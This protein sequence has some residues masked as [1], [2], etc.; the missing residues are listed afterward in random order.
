MG[1]DQELFPNTE[2]NQFNIEVWLPNGGN[3]NQTEDVV[4]RLENEIEKDE[5]VLG[6]ASFVGTSS[7]RFH[8]TYAPEFPRKNFAQIFITTTGKEATQELA[9]EYIKKFEG[10]VPDGYIR[11]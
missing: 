5:R 2:R 11:I 3:L 4:K 7:P 1:L 6:V 8:S 10:F 9:D